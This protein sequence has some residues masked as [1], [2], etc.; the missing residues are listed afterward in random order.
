MKTTNQSNKGILKI[1]ADLNDNL[2]VVF[3]PIDSTV[4]LHKSELPNLFGVYIQTINAC[5]D[6]IFKEKL[7]EKDHVSKYDLYVSGNTIKYDMREFRLEVIIAM[8][9]RID[10]ANAKTLRE[11]FVGR[12]LYPG[13]AIPPMLPD[14]T[15]FCLN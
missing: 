10:S 4:W 7:F 15:D 12:C 14:S 6:S 8:A 3:E 11:W 1:E 5:V 9:F 2:Q 13:I